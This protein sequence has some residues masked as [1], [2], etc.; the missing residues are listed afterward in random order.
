MSEKFRTMLPR[1]KYLSGFIY[2]GSSVPA[3]LLL[4]IVALFSLA[5]DP[6]K[7]A[8]ISDPLEPVNRATLRVNRV[9]DTLVIKPVARTYTQ[10]APKLVKTGVRNVFSNLGEIGAVTNNILQL[11]FGKAASSAGRL[12]INSTIGLAGLIEVADPMFG[13]PK[14]KQDFGQTLAH[15]GVGAGPYIVLPLL[16]PSTVRDAFGAGVDSMLSPVARSDEHSLRDPL[17]SVQTVD[18]RAKYLPFDDLISGDEYLFIREA[19]WQSRR[20]QIEGASQSL[21]FETF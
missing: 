19:Y 12:V 5:T 8:E 15:W 6:V 18:T 2:S 13:L 3:A 9:V 11:E 20:F 4:I 16:G 14:H 7:G 10:L 21:A 17:M 1:Y